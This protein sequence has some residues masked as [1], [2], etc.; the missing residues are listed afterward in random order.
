MR[1]SHFLLTRFSYRPVLQRSAFPGW[2][3]TDDPLD[4]DRLETRF[5]LFTMFCLPSVLQQTNKNFWWL[6]IVDPV[7]PTRY[8]ERLKELCR[9][10]AQTRLIDYESGID[11]GSLRWLSSFI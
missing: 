6:I 3:S 9:A 5:Q 8:R 11:L 10:H 1:L 2:M 4:P 7:L